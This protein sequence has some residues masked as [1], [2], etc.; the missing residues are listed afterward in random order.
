MSK[1]LVNWGPFHEKIQKKS[2]NAE[3]TERGD[4]LTKCQKILVNW[5]PFHEKIQ[6]K[7]HNEKKLKGGTL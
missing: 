5:G 7:S 2:H 1:I 3:K 4:P 6:K